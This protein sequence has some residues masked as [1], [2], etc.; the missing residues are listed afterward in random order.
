MT[1]LIDELTK[2]LKQQIIDCLH[3]DGVV[4]EDLDEDMPLFGDL[5]GLDSIDALE[6]VVLLDK[7]YGIKINDSKAARKVMINIR[8]IA[9]YVMLHRKK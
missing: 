7:K 6:L 3:M 4:P 9:E 8:T 5:T 2:Q 1:Q